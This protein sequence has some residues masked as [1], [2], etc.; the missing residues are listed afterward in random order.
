MFCKS[1]DLEVHSNMEEAWSQFSTLEKRIRQHNSHIEQISPIKFPRTS[2]EPRM[3]E[4]PLLKNQSFHDTRPLAR[5]AV[6]TRDSRE[7]EGLLAQMQRE[8]T[9]M[10]QYKEQCHNLKAQIQLYL[11]KLAHYETQ[12]QEKNRLIKELERASKP[13][14]ASYEV[15]TKELKTFKVKADKAIGQ[16][17]QALEEKDAKLAEVA[18]ADQELRGENDRLSSQLKLEQQSSAQTLSKLNELKAKYMT[19]QREI[20]MKLNDSRLDCD[21]L[22]REN[23]K[24]RAELEKAFASLKLCQ[25]QLAVFPQLQAEVVKLRHETEVTDKQQAHGTAYAR[26]QK[27]EDLET[28]LARYEAAW[29][30]L[31]SKSGGR[32][33][34]VYLDELKKSLGD[35]HNQM[36]EIQID[37]ESLEAQQKLTETELRIAKNSLEKFAKKTLKWLENEFFDSERPEVVLELPGNFL[38]SLSPLYSEI[39]TKLNATRRL[40]FHSLSTLK[41]EVEDLRTQTY[42]LEAQSE[43]LKYSATDLTSHLQRQEQFSASLAEYKTEAD[44]EI[45]KLRSQLVALAEDRLAAQDRLQASFS[46]NQSLKDLVNM[47]IASLGLE[48]EAD[49]LKSSLNELF[50]CFDRFRA[51]LDGKGHEIKALQMHAEAIE[52]TT[53]AREREVSQIKTEYCGRVA[54]MNVQIERLTEIVKANEAA[55]YEIVSRFQEAEGQLQS[56]AEDCEESKLEATLLKEKAKKLADLGE[57]LVQALSASLRRQA[58]LQFQKDLLATQF[59][60]THEAF[61]V[62]TPTLRFRKV[63]IAVL[64]ANRLSRLECSFKRTKPIRYNGVFL[65][66]SQAPVPLEPLPEADDIME[67][68]FTLLLK[69]EST[70]SEDQDFGLITGLN[71]G[72]ER[73]SQTLPLGVSTSIL[74]ILKTKDAET[75][76][77]SRQIQRLHEENRRLE[78]SLNDAQRD[79]TSRLVDREVTIR[80]EAEAEMEQE[81]RTSREDIKEYQRALSNLRQASIEMQKHS[82]LLA[83]RQNTLL[84]ELADAQK[85]SASTCEE[86]VR[87]RQHSEA[88]HRKRKAAEA[89]ADKLELRLKHMERRYIEL[90]EALDQVRQEYGLLTD[91]CR[92]LTAKLTEG[93]VI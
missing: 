46:E 50:R 7:N 42:S 74:K 38:A 66:V 43:T 68:L 81:L 82:E 19:E 37:L 12:L 83:E 5:S 90:S 87:V 9:G 34:V 27:V 29:E 40:A 51:E 41:Q 67:L 16:L 62:T 11:E 71:R 35:S 63:V 23:G 80:F 89:R 28:Q 86:I 44:D 73:V 52:Q 85:H 61:K 72:L 79:S 25:D 55:S 76:H 6:F 2:P 57:T 91:R 39:G 69:A 45:M 33:P 18:H 26:H 20:T 15:E 56:A 22:N 8:L 78:T 24:L 3:P 31:D 21:S 48:V 59:I 30:Q 36:A 93:G 70:A 65:A 64:A 13:R 47:K 58:A 75:Q 10:S 49:D 77:L 92:R 14:I 84:Q 32:D 1:I 60:Q 17:K 54:E 53:Q 88:E 4:V